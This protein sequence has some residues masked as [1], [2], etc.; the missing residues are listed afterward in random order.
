MSRLK[1][2]IES[3][4]RKCQISDFVDRAR[5]WE[6]KLLYVLIEQ[7]ASRRARISLYTYVTSVQARESLVFRQRVWARMTTLWIL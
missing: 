6:G 1:L 3:K 5:E 2:R 4:R 7:I